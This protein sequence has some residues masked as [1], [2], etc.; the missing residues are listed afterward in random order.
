MTSWIDHLNTHTT[1]TIR[2]TCFL[3]AEK[4][5]NH[6]NQIALTVAGILYPKIVLGAAE[7]STLRYSIM[8]V[9]SFG[10]VRDIQV[11]PFYN[12]LK[13]PKT[14]IL[15]LYHSKSQIL[16]STKNKTKRLYLFMFIKNPNSDILILN[17][18]QLI[19]LELFKVYIEKNACI[20]SIVV[21]KYL[22]KTIQLIVLYQTTFIILIFI[23]T[24]FYDF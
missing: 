17:N 10:D 14:V 13:C 16:S 1:S 23:F 12:E 20:F 24:I 2:V 19:Y 22:H 21:H 11:H 7:L 4:D 5:S 9:K 8:E 15:C 18:I 3:R 6:S